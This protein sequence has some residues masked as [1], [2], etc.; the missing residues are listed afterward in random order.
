MNYICQDDRTTD[1]LRTWSGTQG[2]FI[3]DFF[4]WNAGTTLEKS[5]KGLLRSLLYQVLKRFP[6]LHS[7]QNQS[8]PGSAY[9]SE[10]SREQIAAWTERR[11]HATFDKVIRQAQEI[12]RIC[13]FI[14]GL[15]ETSEEPDAAIAVIKKMQSAN[16][17]ICLSSRPDRSYTD[18]FE[19]SAKLRLQDLT[20][21]DIRRY[22]VHELQLSLPTNSE[23]EISEILDDISSKAKG[24][25]L[26]V[27]LVVKALKNGLRNDDS[28]EQLRIRVD[29]MPSGMEALYAKMLSNIDIAYHEEG[30]QLFQIALAN[31]TDSL[32][33]IT[34][35][36][37][38]GFERLSEL[39]LQ[40]ALG[41]CKRSLWRIPVICAGLLEVHQE[42]RDSEEGGGKIENFENYVTLP[43]RYASS[44]EI[45]D[46]SYFERYTH[47]EFVHRTAMDFLRQSKQ[48]R[49]FLEQNAKSCSSAR[50][51]YIRALLAKVT[52]LG[53][54]TMPDRTDAKSKENA[55]LT[56]STNPR[57]SFDLPGYD[58]VQN[59]T[60]H[61][62]FEEWNTAVAQ[63]TLCDDVDRT[64]ANVC[65]R[66]LD[67]SPD[68]PWFTRW[69]RIKGVDG[70][71][72][73]PPWPN[74]S[75]Q[76]SSQVSFRSARSEP[77]DLQ[78]RQ[79]DFPG[80]AVDRGLR[81]YVI[82]KFDL[83]QDH[84]DK[85]YVNYLLCC[86]VQA[87]EWSGHFFQQ[88][89]EMLVEK[90]TLIND[91]LSRGGNPNSYVES[92][93]NTIWGQ[94]LVSCSSWG[95]YILPCAQVIQIASATTAKA[96]LKAGADAGV[97]H[98]RRNLD[99][100][101][102][103]SA[104]PSP[105]GRSVIHIQI[106]TEIS[107][108][109]AVRIS[110]RY[111]PEWKAVEEII[112]AKGGYESYKYTH[113]TLYTPIAE[114]RLP[115]KISRRQHEK[116]L[117]ALNAAHHDYLM[118][119]RARI[120]IPVLRGICEAH[121][122]QF[123]SDDDTSSDTDAEEEFYESLDKQSAVVVQEHHTGE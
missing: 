30:A 63:V 35:A 66:Y 78:P 36:L 100:F 110:L 54:P 113:V 37:S 24:V 58:F 64:L 97:K 15:D 62:F 8:A 121:L 33:D 103:R 9:E 19:S 2:V 95:P 16:I 26:W 14:D 92:F 22:I 48:G 119:C 96:F 40:E 88:R 13:I 115:Y 98:L 82:A 17:K 57:G 31:L 27:K 52:L 25:F 53:I 116:L 77:M 123:V 112:L 56:W 108:L 67:F 111:L 85:E 55:R 93:S 76:S 61:V 102:V 120:W 68:S 73:V 50:S 109:N 4:F 90:F 45:A 28:L 39:S 60:W 70:P 1:L 94:F 34:L 74:M 5:S 23:N 41:L 38:K 49:C 114:S 81:R 91:L 106:H 89:L 6:S 99:L 21:P 104:S 83:R 18:A 12:C 87:I 101:S 46:I 10:Q 3:P 20:E 80:F 59:I 72:P 122:R 11:L 75:S 32:L 69:T 42:D 79:I 117:T 84:P 7:C 47:V 29:S 107:V 43:C 51:S 118:Y 86:C 44:L 71:A 65:Q 105:D